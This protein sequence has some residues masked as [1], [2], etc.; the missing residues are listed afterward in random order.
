MAEAVLLKP[1]RKFVEEII[2]SGGG[3]LKLCCQC[4]TCSVVCDLSSD[5]S[6]F[7]RKEMIWAQWGLKDRLMAD[8]DVW[9]CHQC[10]DCSERCT[11]GAKPGD[12]LAAVREQSIKHYATPQFLAGMVNRVKQI[13]V[14]F[15]MMPGILLLLALLLRHPIE[16][17][18]GLGG[19]VH[20]EAFYA[21]F[22]PHWL[23][24]AF[25]TSLTM[26]AFVGLIGGLFKYW[27]AMKAA[28]LAKGRQI[29][30]TG[31]L[32]SFIR[33][34]IAVLTHKQFGRCTQRVNRK[35]THLYA[36][37]GFIALFVVTV[38]AVFDLYLF[39]V[40]GLDSM[41]PFN[42]MHPMK[43]LANIGGIVLITGCVKGILDRKKDTSDSSGSTSSDSIFIWLLL[44]VGIT[45]FITEVFRF[46]VGVNA[47][48]G[49]MQYMAYTI[50]F[51]HL[52][53]VFGLLVYLP[54]SKFAHIW[55]RTLAMV[56]AEYSGRTKEIA[57][58]VSV[59][60]VAAEVQQ[61]ETQDEETSTEESKEES[62]EESE[63]A[64]ESDS[65]Q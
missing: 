60:P 22:F 15:M 49:A 39:P 38:Y 2:D 4:A 7:P 36:F 40:L 1:D 13:P 54:Y 12:V 26:L 35:T 47:H 23:L 45:G 56:Y 46:T 21:S 43:I 27:K 5:S 30:E 57:G 19:S 28:D 61:A 18:L 24:I 34:V 31:V 20:D 8:P 9:L 48:G 50:Y 16:G 37:Y 55:Y 44:L 6:P 63:S 14:M 51:V 25:Y 59:T 33:T 52:M 10:M 11:R 17:M 62:E 3:D 41:Y 58:T 29:G 64:N 42:L 32:T 53:C 65:T